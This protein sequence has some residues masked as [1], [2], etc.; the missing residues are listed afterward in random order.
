MRPNLEAALSLMQK[1]PCVNVLPAKSSQYL[2]LYILKSAFFNRLF[3]F[4]A[5]FAFMAL[6]GIFSAPLF[7]T[8]LHAQVSGSLSAETDSWFRGR[9]ISRGQPVITAN[10]SYD[11]SSGIYVDGSTAFTIGEQTQGPLSFTGVIGHAANIAPNISIDNGAVLTAYT[12]RYTGQAN[13]IFVEFYSGLSYKNITGRIRYSPDFQELDAQTLYFEL[14]AAHR[15]ADGLNATA[16]AGLLQQVG[17]NGSLGERRFRYDLQLA[18]AKDIDLWT[19]R[20]SVN[21][22]GDRGG[23]YFA[24]PFRLRDAIILGV[25]RSF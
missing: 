9:S 22:G 17:G 19:L 10:L 24:G 15:L 4:I 1:H 12:D 18:I 8:P 14:D 6:F 20:A 5:P 13:D 2:K 7:I 25:S 11:D 21:Y 3:G 16:H 23:T